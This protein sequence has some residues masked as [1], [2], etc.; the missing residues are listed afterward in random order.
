MTDSARRSKRYPSKQEL[1]VR[2]ESWAEF[3]QLY[4]AD[5]SQ[6]GMFILTSEAPPILSEIEVD[7]RLPEGH[8]I[9]LR[10]TVVHVLPP[11]QA[12]I[13]GRQPGVGVQFIELDPMHKQQIYQLIEFARWDGS[14]N[15]PTASYASRLFET[16]AALPPGKV[17]D[18]LPP[19]ASQAKRNTSTQPGARTSSRA[20]ASARATQPEMTAPDMARKT[21]PEMTAPDMARKTSSER[22]RK[23]TDPAPPANAQAA[24][25]SAPP[26][27]PLAQAPTETP[28]AKPLDMAKLKLGMTHLAHKRLDQAIKTFEA[29]LVESP[30]DRQAGQWLYVARARA[31]LKDDDEK[32]AIEHYQ[33]VLEIDETNHEARKFVREHHQK[34]RLTSLPFGRYFV[35]KT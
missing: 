26:A 5:V 8:H 31:R 32:G 28:T 9:Q 1:L 21:Q 11:E 27:Q 16:S 15:N 7:L 34:K 23:P 4:A 22:P 33:K 6:G 35:K 17:L 3:A 29:L 25:P 14:S 13:Q 2:C 12:A 20:T 30:G 10:A 19:D 24:S 18:A